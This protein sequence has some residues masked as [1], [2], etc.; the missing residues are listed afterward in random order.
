MEME[1]VMLWIILCA[2]KYDFVLENFYEK[3]DKIFEKSAENAG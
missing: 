2:T 1:C 3:F